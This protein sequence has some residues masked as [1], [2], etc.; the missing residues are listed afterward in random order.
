MITAKNIFTFEQEM[1]RDLVS[2]IYESGLP[3][4][5]IEA[6]FA[7]FGEMDEQTYGDLLKMLSERQNQPLIRLKAGESLKASEINKA[8]KRAANNE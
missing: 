8:V 1:R 3:G 4:E 6:I 7:G 5:E 2:Q